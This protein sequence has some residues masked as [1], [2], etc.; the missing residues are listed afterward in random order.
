MILTLVVQ[1]AS[2]ELVVGVPKDFRALKVSLVEE[3]VCYER[4][5]DFNVSVDGHGEKGRYSLLDSA[6]GHIGGLVLQFLEG[7]GGVSHVMCGRKKE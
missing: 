1:Q 3:A 2:I 5:L 7:R 6:A 4:Q